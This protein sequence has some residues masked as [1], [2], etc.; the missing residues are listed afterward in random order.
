MIIRRHLICFSLLTTA[1]PLTSFAQTPATPVA[2]LPRFFVGIGG[3]FGGYPLPRQSGVNVATFVP[4][5]G[6]QLRPRLALQVSGAYDASH[7]Y[8][9]YD[10]GD[11]QPNGEQVKRTNWNRT[12]VVPVLARYALT[13]RATQRFQA[14]VLGGVSYV[15]FSVRSDVFRM[16]ADGALLSTGEETA[17]T[18]SACLTLGGGLRYIVCPRFELTADA[19]LNRQIT[20]RTRSSYWVNP[21]LAAGVRYRFGRAL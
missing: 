7:S 2:P 12:L 11:G 10:Y 13:R 15:R 3:S 8:T 17:T 4:T 19:V 9:N 1:L 5:V 21:N 16:S 18:N 6:M 20:S 14:D